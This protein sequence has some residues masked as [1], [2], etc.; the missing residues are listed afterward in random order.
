MYGSFNP[1]LSITL[2]LNNLVRKIIKQKGYRG[3]ESGFSRAR[4]RLAPIGKPANLNH[5]HFSGTEIEDVT[6]CIR[7]MMMQVS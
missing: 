7:K 2:M 3:S 6:I 4:V 5:S 1:Q